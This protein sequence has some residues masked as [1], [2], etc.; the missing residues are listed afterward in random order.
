ML[1]AVN[2]TLMRGCELNPNMQAAGAKFVRQTKTAPIYR[3]WSIDD[4]YVGMLRDP[5]AGAEITV[6]LWDVDSS[7]LVDI[8]QKEPP[9]L[10]I[11]KVLLTDGRE[12][13]GVLAEPYAIAGNAEITHHGGWREYIDSRG[14]AV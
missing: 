9:G 5:Q 4:G 10:T 12:V 11:G 6:E 2:G 8:L 1:L 13:L 3:C 7:G 14:E